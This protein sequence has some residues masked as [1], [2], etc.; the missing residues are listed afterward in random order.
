MPIIHYCS[1]PTSLRWHLMAKCD[2]KASRNFGYTLWQEICHQVAVKVWQRALEICW[3]CSSLCYTPIQCQSSTIIASLHLWGATWWP[4]DAWMLAENQEFFLI[5]EEA[6]QHG[7]V[8]VWWRA[9]QSCWECSSTCYTPIQCQTSTIAAPACWYTP[10]WWPNIGWELAEN[11]D[12]F[13]I[14]GMNPAYMGL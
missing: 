6:C 13:L 9:L 8:K 1:K 3:E 11:R 2:L 14:W 10:T 12:F 7:A 5:S 4:N